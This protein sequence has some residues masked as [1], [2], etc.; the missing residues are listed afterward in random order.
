MYA[1]TDVSTKLD[2]QIAAG[3]QSRP[4]FTN[5][6]ISKKTSL[7]SVD[8]SLEPGDLKQFAH[9]S[10]PSLKG[11]YTVA[12][13]SSNKC[14]VHIFW[15]NKEDLNYIELTPGIPSSMKL[16]ADKSFYFSFYAQDNEQ[17]KESQRDQITVYF[18]TDIRA[19]IYMLKT[20]GELD[21][22]SSSNYLWKT[23]TGV[24]GGVTKIHVPPSDAAYCVECTYVG[25]V[26]VMEDGAI[27][28]LPDIRHDGIALLLTPGFTVPDKLLQ[29]EKQYY[30][31]YNP[32][33]DLLDLT[34]SMLSGF[35]TIYVSDKPEITPTSFVDSYKLDETLE[36]QK[37]IIINPHKYNITTA[38]TF[39][40]LVVNEKADEAS[41]TIDVDKNS[42]KTPI[43][44]G[45]T[46][47]LHLAPGESTDFFYVPKKTE[48]S[49]EVR[50]E[51]RQVLK[52]KFVA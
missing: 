6:A 35:V 25:Y 1:S 4:P 33:S 46:K 19:N 52:P 15:N 3:L 49:F 40:L 29:H 20:N 7:G 8:L 2:L 22:P 32:D 36:V 44:P 21:A 31:V 38:S 18:K 9:D 24:M 26:E 10:T 17:G 27:T 39:Y 5:R 45:M 37:Y 41:Y 50:V 16:E 28:L 34:I 14:I 48:S 47:Y 11:H 43:S 13:R 51:L 12:L 42:I 23:S 30:R